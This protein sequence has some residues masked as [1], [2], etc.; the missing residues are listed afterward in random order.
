MSP[1]HEGY[2]KDNFRARRTRF[3]GSG[4]DYAAYEVS[5]VRRP[6]LRFLRFAGLFFWLRL[7]ERDAALP[8]PLTDAVR[9]GRPPSSVAA[10]GSTNCIRWGPR[11]EHF[12]LAPGATRGSPFYK[13][14]LSLVY[15]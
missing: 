10:G 12:C 1:T 2:N 6:I 3:K 4:F 13:N 15:F 9:A 14:P 7:R 5:Q 11:A 8:R